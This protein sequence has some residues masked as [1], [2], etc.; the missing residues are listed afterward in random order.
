MT[1]VTVTQQTIEELTARLKGS[2]AAVAH[3]QQTN[4]ELARI[5]ANLMRS[6]LSSRLAV[7]NLT[8]AGE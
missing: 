7:E 6:N 5:I 1:Q 2:E 8:K 4:A 3:L